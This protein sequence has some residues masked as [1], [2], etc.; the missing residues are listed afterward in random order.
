VTDEFTL[1]APG[2]EGSDASARDASAASLDIEEFIPGK[3]WQ[4]PSIRSADDDPY[5]T[6]GG[7]AS[8]VTNDDRRGSLKTSQ[9]MLAATQQSSTSN[10]VWP[11]GTA[12]AHGDSAGHNFLSVTARVPPGLVPSSSHWLQQ[13]PAFTRSTSWTPQSSSY[14]ESC[15]VMQSL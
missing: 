15:L 6:P 13:Q 4:G 10:N 5:I 7:T 8:A 11:V 9:D 2:M 1:F 3:L 14:G 12:A